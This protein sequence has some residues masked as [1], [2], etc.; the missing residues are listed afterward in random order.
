MKSDFF[1]IIYVVGLNEIKKKGKQKF[2]I[3]I[4]ANCPL[5]M[6]INLAQTLAHF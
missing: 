3:F 2:A 6:T 1:G 4:I 5:K